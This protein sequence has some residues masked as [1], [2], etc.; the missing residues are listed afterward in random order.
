LAYWDELD[1]RER[2]LLIKLIGG[3]FRVGVSR[4]LVTRALAPSPPRR[5]ADRPA[6]DGLDRRQVSPTGAGFL[7]LIAAQS[8]GEH[9]QRGGQPYPFFLAHPCRR[10]GHLGDSATGRWNGNTTACAPSWCARRQNWLWSR[11]EELI[12]ER[13][14]ELAQLACPTAPCSMAKS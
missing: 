11:G 6:P 8:D 12:T 9:A 3:G 5:Q 7:K 13:F 1:T 10:A 2:F 4:L 14:P